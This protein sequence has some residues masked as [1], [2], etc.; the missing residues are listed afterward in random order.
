M[1][2]NFQDQAKLDNSKTEQVRSGRKKYRRFVVVFLGIIVLAAGSFFIWE[3]YFSQQA[4]LNE[5]AQ[6]NY[7]KYLTFQENYEKAMTEDTYGGKTPEETLQMFIDAL[8]KEDVQLASKYFLLNTNEKS[9]Y[10]LTRKEW[11]AGLRN[12][13]KKDELESVLNQLSKVQL[14]FKDDE[15]ALF[16]FYNTN[17]DVVVLIELKFNKYSGVWK[18]ESM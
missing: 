4:K 1:E 12:V 6:E 16:K 13:K 2:Q 15:E 8:E 18:I 5:Q 17:G 3:K 10:Y 7:E 11:E 9:E 14:T